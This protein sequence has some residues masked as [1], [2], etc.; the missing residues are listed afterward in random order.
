MVEIKDGG[1]SVQ[2]LADSVSPKGNRIVTIVGRYWRG[3]HAEFMT[4]R[5]F[6]RNAASSR[7]IPVKK[8]MAQVWNEPFVPSYWGKNQ[9]G[10]QAKDELTGWRRKL[11]IRIWLAARLFALVLAWL[12]LKIGNHKQI[13]NRLLEPWMWITVIFTTTS[14]TNFEGLRCHPDAEPHFQKFAKMVMSAFRQ[15]VPRKLQ[16]GQWHLPYVTEEEQQNYC[17]LPIKDLLKLS[18]GRCARVSYLTHDGIRDPQKDIELHDRMM[19]SVPL[20][21]SPAEHQAQAVEG[22]TSSGNLRGEWFQYRKSFA[23]EYIS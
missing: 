14:L 9:A 18:V 6:G 3:I 5:E 7:A 20:H 17:V 4:H 15:S 2:I 22:V 10:M 8:L 19:V 1:F 11:S 13:A 23:N 21:A 16:Y 12:L